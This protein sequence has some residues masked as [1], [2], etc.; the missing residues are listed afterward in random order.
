[1]IDKYATGETAELRIGDRVYHLPIIE[2]SEGERAID[3]RK[4]RAETGY[5]TIDSGYMN[6]G[7]CASSI[8]FLD[9]EKS[10]LNYRGY[11]IADLAE[12]CSFIE[13]AYLL[14]NGVLPTATELEDFESRVTR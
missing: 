5:I 1:M 4:L 7:A 2:G 9:G 8:T 6:T 14:I 11:S 13:V 10:I 12:H 3:V